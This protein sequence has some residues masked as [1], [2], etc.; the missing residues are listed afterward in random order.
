MVVKSEVY[1]G[2]EGIGRDIQKM[3]EYF[4]E[5]YGLLASTRAARLHQA[6]H[7][8]AR[9]FG[10][11]G[12]C[13]NVVKTVIME[14]QPCCTT[15]GHSTEAYSVWMMGEWSTHPECLHMCVQYPECKVELASG[16][17]ATHRQVQHWV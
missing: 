7:V 10:R 9:I 11:V 5:D 4:Y 17:L 1:S 16:S 6:F 12:L 14:C 15:G 2:S 13:T 3:L 8:L